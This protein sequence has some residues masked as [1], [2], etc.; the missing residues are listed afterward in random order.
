MLILFKTCTLQEEDLMRNAIKRKTSFMCD[1][2]AWDDIKDRLIS[3]E[4]INNRQKG[5][6]ESEKGDANKIMAMLDIFGCTD[7]TKTYQ[8]FLRALAKSG[9]S[10][11]LCVTV[12]EKELLKQRESVKLSSLN[13]STTNIQMK[14]SP[15]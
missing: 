12:I 9:G 7:L 4:I 15:D 1:H 10:G 14:Y 5:R 2:L 3:K 11:Q 8:K 13:N 6:I